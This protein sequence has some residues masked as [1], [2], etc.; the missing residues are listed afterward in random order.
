MSE[1]IERRIF[2]EE[3]E[4]RAAAGEDGKRNIEGYA[5][6]FN[7]MSRDLGGFRERFLPTAFDAVLRTNPD[8]VALFNHDYNLILGRTRAGTLR[9]YSDTKGLG[10]VIQPPASRGDVIEAIDRGD[11]RGSSFAFTVTKKGG[12]AWMDEGGVLVREVRNVAKLFDVSPV[13]NPAYPDTSVA[14]RSMSSATVRQIQ[15]QTGLG[16]EDIKRRIRFLEIAREQH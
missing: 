12:D 8:V 11:V 1:D 3:T 16:L 13:V 5:V 2:D 7:S 6:M 10:Y 15:E 4:I 9:I 14:R